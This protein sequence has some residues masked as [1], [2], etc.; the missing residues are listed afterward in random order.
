MKKISKNVNKLVGDIAIKCVQHNFSFNLKAKKYILAG[1]GIKC[2]G[3][4]DEKDMV[5]AALKDGWVDVLTHESCHLDQ[6][7]E[8]CKYWRSGE[9]GII[10]FDKW[11]TKK[12][13]VSNARLEKAIKNTILLELD[14]EQ[15]TVKK[16]KK[17][18]IKFNEA[19]YIQRANSY[20]L[21]YWAS[22]RDRK[23][24]PFPYE[25]K[26][27][28]NNMPKIFMKPEKYLTS[29]HEWLKLYK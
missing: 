27:I 7:V 6:F 21:S 20:L 10:L 9:D 25:K 5:V 18:N 19:N 3:Y 1:K 29:D 15:R 16:M 24:Y 23:W 26:I 11:L 4:F 12:A 8:N 14:C 13:N 28:Y 22:Y 2:S 17:Y